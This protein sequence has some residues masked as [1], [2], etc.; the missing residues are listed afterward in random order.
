ML[1]MLDVYLYLVPV[2]NLKVPVQSIKN[3]LREANVQYEIL[4]LQT[5]ETTWY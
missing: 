5:S 1:D 3:T 4:P 2:V